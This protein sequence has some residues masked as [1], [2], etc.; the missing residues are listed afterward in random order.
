MNA[1]YALNG[2]SKQ[3]HFDALQRAI[4]IELKEPCY[5]GFIASIRDLHPGMGLRKVYEQ[6]SP[7]GIGRDA[8]IS[9]GLR[10]G[11]RLKSLLDKPHRTTFSVKSNRFT[12]L[13]G[14]K[15]FTDVNQVWVSD[16]FYFPLNDKHYYVVLIMDVY[17]RKIVG[18]SV[19]DNMRA[20][21]NINALQAALTLR[22]INDYKKELIH[23][24]DRGSQYVSDDY[25]NL[26]D[27][28]GIAISMC[29]DVLENAHS[30]RA[31]GTIKNEYLSRW[32]ITDFAELKIKVKLAI[33]NYN[34]RLHWSI[35]ATPNNYEIALKEMPIESKTK[36]EIFTINKAKINSSQIELFN[37]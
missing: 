11:Y 25:T 12:N 35:G 2:I 23:H 18:Y 4:H 17:S 9:L 28:Y 34:N 27:D 1:L 19:A 8:F 31:N 5:V 20:E 14:G 24:S 16:L 32:S 6:F 36:M 21:N 15:W 22:G 29:I 37:L 30:E 10:A 13:L 3:G 33:D 26:L 7:E